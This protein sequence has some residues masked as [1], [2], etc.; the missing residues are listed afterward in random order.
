MP[1]LSG[2]GCTFDS[3]VPSTVAIDC[4]VEADC[5][6]GWTC[7]TKVGRCIPVDSNDLDDPVILDYDIIT[8]NGES[9][10]GWRNLNA[11]SRSRTASVRG[12]RGEANPLVRMN[13][14]SGW[15]PGGKKASAAKK[16][17]LHVHLH[18]LLLRH[19]SV[20][21]RE[22]R[23]RRR[24]RPRSQRPNHHEGS[25]LQKRLLRAERHSI[26]PPTVVNVSELVPARVRE[27]GQASFD[28]FDE[29]G[30][31]SINIVANG[32]EGGAF[33]IE[34]VA[35]ATDNP[36]GDAGASELEG[37]IASYRATFTAPADG[38][39]EQDIDGTYPV[40]VTATDLFGNTS[41][42][43]ELNDPL[44][45][46]NEPPEL[47][48]LKADNFSTYGTVGVDEE[49]R[50]MGYTEPDNACLTATFSEAL[51]DTASSLQPRESWT[52]KPVARKPSRS[53]KHVAKINS[54]LKVNSPRRGAL[55]R[56]HLPA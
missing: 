46:D 1:G 5:L 10:V 20:H 22:L 16:N 29:P 47:T 23:L 21:P 15:K 26:S 13:A 30:L 24:R 9:V 17:P 3:E 54:C 2:T 33:Q 4:T 51:D 19:R 43:H 41:S 42:P 28:T 36:V 31:G 39:G 53:P 37:T 38:A 7:R 40:T 44:I 14:E 48:D 52:P 27:N 6:E 56:R 45:I 35:P 18:R 25:S 49:L 34:S 55:A 8:E 11:Y 50:V 32:L 12:R